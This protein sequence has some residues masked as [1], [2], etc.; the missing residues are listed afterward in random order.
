MVRA[1]SLQVDLRLKIDKA[2][3]LPDDMKE[4]LREKVGHP[5]ELDLRSPWSQVL[6]VC[7]QTMEVLPSPGLDVAASSPGKKTCSKPLCMQFSG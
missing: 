7:L 4:A 1:L 2:E 3:W 5:P 6:A